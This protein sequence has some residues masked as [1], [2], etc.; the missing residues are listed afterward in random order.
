MLY[1]ATAFLTGLVIVTSWS[2]LLHEVP[3]FEGFMTN[4]ADGILKV[5]CYLACVAAISAVQDYAV[6]RLKLPGWTK[7][8]AANSS[9]WEKK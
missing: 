2:N 5:S 4:P 7:G 8:L 1:D 6:F 3:K 9:W